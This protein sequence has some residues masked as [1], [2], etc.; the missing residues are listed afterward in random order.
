MK[1]K[2]YLSIIALGA[3][4][5]SACSKDYYNDHFEGLEDMQTITDVRTLEYTLT[6]D[7]YALMAK[8]ASKISSGN[9]AAFAAIGAAKGFESVEQAQSLVPY[10]IAYT[11]GK[12]FMLSNNSSIKLTYNVLTAGDSYMSEIT[13][14]L[15]TY[16][17]AADDYIAAWG[18]EEDYVDMLTPNTI[19][20]LAASI[21]TEGYAAGDYVAV[22][23]KYAESEPVFT[24]VGGGSEAAKYVYKPV[25][26]PSGADGKYLFVAAGLEGKYYAAT[27]VNDTSGAGYGYAQSFEV[28]VSDGV[29]IPEENMVPNDHSRNIEN[30]VF[31]L[32][33][34]SGNEY[35]L[36]N[37]FDNSYYYVTSYAS[38]SYSSSVGEGSYTYVFADADGGATTEMKNVG[39][40]RVF[41][42]VPSK[43]QWNMYA[44]LGETDQVYPKLYRRE[45][46]EAETL[47][48]A[49]RAAVT[50]PASV[51]KYAF[52]KFDGSKFAAVDLAVI[53]PSDYTVMGNTYG[54]ITDGTQSQ[55][56]PKFL[57][58]TYPYAKADDVKYVA[59]RLYAGGSTD[60]TV[61]KYLFDGTT[62]GVEANLEAV[63]DQFVRQ[64]GK[65]LWNPSVVINLPVGRNQPLSAQYFQAVTDWVYENIDVPMGSSGK[66]SGDY[67]VT[68]YGNNEYY[69]GASAYQGN[70][71][72]RA[73]A[74]K[75]QYLGD[76]YQG[77]EFVAAGI[78]FPGD[79][80]GNLSDE[81]IQNLLIKR[82]QFVLG[83]VLG[84]LHSDAAP[85]AG[86]DITYTIKTGFYNGTSTPAVT[87]VYR[88]VGKGEF[89]FVE[90][91]GWDE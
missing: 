89:E 91:T 81:E 60:W 77:S 86:V 42:F 52:F 38:F 13:D 3:L 16:T 75:G 58:M 2:K 8:D 47:S 44:S 59:Y 18:S 51:N 45:A 55:Y 50:K 63:T 28:T 22:T 72:V 90:M 84:V 82:F 11:G 40:N 68:S 70:V 34:A 88:V 35:Y 12:F 76:S 5:F 21:P 49:T 27:N 66:T 30:C 53:Q 64:N 83:K 65:W 79:G 61:D 9:Q 85:I 46:V 71:D 20:K 87:L 29:I 14:N 32:E 25:D 80:Y 78:A 62:W 39:A 74:A 48:A 33:P 31:L 4:V 10:Y 19:S 57:E 1:I 54:N 43:K 15:K 24:E 23:Y 36:H 37:E 26:V 41:V 56:L 69:T 17:L 67:F 7:D 6:D 73:S